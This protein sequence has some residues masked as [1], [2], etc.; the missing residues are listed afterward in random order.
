[1][2]LHPISSAVSAFE[3]RQQ[4][5]PCS[6]AALDDTQVQHLAAASVRRGFVLKSSVWEQPGMQDTVLL[7]IQ[8]RFRLQ[9][10]CR[11][12]GRQI[13]FQLARP[14]ALI[15]ASRIVCEQPLP[16]VYADIRPPVRRLPKAIA[17]PS[18]LLGRF[19]DENR[20]FARALLREIQAAAD[21]LADEV[22]TLRCDAFAE[23]ALVRIQRELGRNSGELDWSQADLAQLVGGTRFDVSRELGRLAPFLGWHGRRGRLVVQDLAEARRLIAYR[24]ELAGDTDLHRYSLRNM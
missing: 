19:F 24:K 13:L 6:L 23:R 3:L 9:R 15:G 4:I 8:G 11:D 2:S 7:V 22:V 1:M 10:R 16:E 20:A 12:N 5:E 17:M 21:E 14:G 18:S